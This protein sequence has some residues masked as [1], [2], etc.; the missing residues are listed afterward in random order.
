MVDLPSTNSTF[1]THTSYFSAQDLQNPCVDFAQIS[2]DAHQ[3]IAL[4]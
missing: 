1:G 3:F 2:L 4:I